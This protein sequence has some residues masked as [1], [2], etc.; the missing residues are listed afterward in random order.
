V[1]TRIGCGRPLAG[2][3]S[4]RAAALA[5]PLLIQG[6]SWLPF[7]AIRVGLFAIIWSEICDLLTEQ[8]SP[9]INNRN[10]RI[11]ATMVNNTFG[12]GTAEN[13]RKPQK[14]AEN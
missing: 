12:W 14:T 7:C 9:E 6:Y 1:A 13:H 5:E 8:C 11:E 10:G 2:R 4:W 3:P